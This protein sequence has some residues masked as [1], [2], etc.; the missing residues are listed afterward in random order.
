MAR[1]IGRPITPDDKKKKVVSISLDPLHLSLLD[2]MAAFDNV[3]RSQLVRA[4]IEGAGIL[5]GYQIGSEAHAGT[6]NYKFASGRRA[7]NPHL[8]KGRCQNSACEAVY[9]KEVF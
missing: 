3:T 9:A 2:Q 1:N 5:G 6:Q 8:L 7:C 4:L